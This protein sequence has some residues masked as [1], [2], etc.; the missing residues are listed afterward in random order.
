MTLRPVMIIIVISGII[1]THLSLPQ[2]RADIAA[3][4]L[5]CEFIIYDSELNQSQM[6]LII[7]KEDWVLNWSL[8]DIFIESN[9]L[10]QNER[11]QIPA[12]EGTLAFG[13]SHYLNT[14][15]VIDASW[16]NISASIE[17]VYKENGRET[18]WAWAKVE[19][20]AITY[21]YT[22][23]LFIGVIVLIALAWRYP[24]WFE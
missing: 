18:A 20:G 19:E 10:V 11:T 6:C 7:I 14:T 1:L 24:H 5:K 4:P 23:I 21:N 13:E 15:E 16:L 2:T 22:L 12:P 17:V 9:K 8:Y 3:P